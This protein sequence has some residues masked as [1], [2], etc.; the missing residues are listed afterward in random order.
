MRHYLIRWS[1]TRW[2][3]VC[4]IHCHKL[5]SWSGHGCI[6]L[7]SMG[8]AF[9]FLFAPSI[10]TVTAR[11]AAHHIMWWKSKR[12]IGQKCSTANSE[13]I[14]FYSQAP[15]EETPLLAPALQKKVLLRRGNIE[16]KADRVV[17]IHDRR[18][19]YCFIGVH[20]CWIDFKLCIR[21]G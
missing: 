19:F 11:I 20:S 14:F 3:I 17:R 6:I 4:K 18:S 2:Q 8:Q 10:R 12:L 16:A 15:V 1:Q 9:Y 21:Y 5:L 7:A 13:G